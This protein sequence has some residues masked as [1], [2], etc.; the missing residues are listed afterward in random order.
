VLTRLVVSA[1]NAHR[2]R[3]VADL[4]GYHVAFAAAAGL[5]AAGL[6]VAVIATGPTA[7]DEEAVDISDTKHATTALVG[8][9][10]TWEEQL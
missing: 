4:G 6:A 2:S 9:R 10:S 8:A 3:L 7:A 1:C 5:V